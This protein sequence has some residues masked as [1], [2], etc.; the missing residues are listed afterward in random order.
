[1]NLSPLPIQRFY[2]NNNFP[3]V[4]GKLF[5]YIAGTTT[6]IATYTDSTGGTPNSNPVILNYRGEAQVW[7]D[8]TL[9][10]KFVLAPA[11]DTDPP[12]NPFWSVDQLTTGLSYAGLIALLTQQFLGQIIYPRTVAEIAVPVT[13]TAYIYP[14]G[15]IRRYGAATGATTNHLALNSALAVSSAGGRPCY[16]PSGDWKVTTTFSAVGVSCMY[17]DGYNSRILVQGAIDGLTFAVQ[18]DLTVRFFRDF[19]L[20]GSS[21]AVNGIICNMTAASGQTISDVLFMGLYITGFAQGVFMRGL[22]ESTFLNCRLFNNYQGYYFHGQNIVNHI[23]GGFIQKGSL[24]GAG[25]QYGVLADVVSGETTQSLHLTDT[26]VYAYDVLV[27][28][29]TV[30]YG[31][32]TNCDLSVCAQICVQIA[33]CRGGI[34]IRNNWIQTNNA[35]F[36]TVGVQVVGVGTAIDD[37]VVIDANQISCTLANAG[38]IGIDVQTAN[39]GVVTNNNTIGSGFAGWQFAIGIKNGGV[40]HN[41]VMQGNTIAATSQAIFASSLAADLVI[42]PN[43]IVPGPSVAATMAAASANVGVPSSA[44]FPVG[45]P[46]QVDATANG[47]TVGVTYYVLTSAANVLTLGASVGAAAIVATGAT[48]V[49]LFIKF[50]PVNFTAATP[51]GLSLSARGKYII[52]LS[53]FAAPLTGVASWAANGREVSV[54]GPSAGI[55]AASTTNA[56]VGSNLPP[57]L[58]PVT[59]QFCDSHIQNNTVPNLSS[60]GVNFATGLISFSADVTGAVFAAAGTK[61]LNGGTIARYPYA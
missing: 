49:N 37:K 25:T 44:A 28:W 31:T 26:A 3:L 29:N 34:F 16:V 35:S 61:G 15:D 17:G 36:A 42:G 11:T 45:S 52:S 2:D 19:S 54:S 41:H 60:T 55:L 9:T 58:W 13:P 39:T 56:M 23:I 50:D 27:S 33:T 6:K 14:E 20:I 46:V 32:I 51:A 30:L 21:G 38:S 57:Y 5:T 24:V 8:P 10:Y 7:I 4:G 53:G 48:A 22:W 43:Y 59:T 12:T 40:A 18:P 1:M 47:F